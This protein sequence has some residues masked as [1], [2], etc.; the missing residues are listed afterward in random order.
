METSVPAFCAASH[1]LPGPLPMGYTNVDNFLEG[2]LSDPSK[3]YSI[4]V[5]AD[6]VTCVQ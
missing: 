1:C 5:E 3:A 2:S 4:R 6:F